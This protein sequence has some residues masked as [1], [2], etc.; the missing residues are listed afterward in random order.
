M[1]LEVYGGSR[2]PR[3]GRR[4]RDEAM[5]KYPIESVDIVHRVGSLSVGET[6]PP[7]SSS[8]PGTGKRRFA[9]CA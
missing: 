1:E 5:Q 4:S 2:G 8:V 3:N 9:A 7:S 6:I